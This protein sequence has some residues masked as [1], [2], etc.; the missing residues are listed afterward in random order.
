[1][2]WGTLSSKKWCLQNVR[3]VCGR[4]LKRKVLNQFSPN[5]EDTYQLSQ[6]WCTRW[7]FERFWKSIPIWAKKVLS[8]YKEW[9]YWF[10]QN[11]GQ[12]QP[13]GFHEV[14]FCC[15]HGLLWGP[16]LRE[17]CNVISKEQWHFSSPQVID[18][19]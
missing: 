19:Y 17:Q 5:L 10:W 6:Y 14:I 2:F 11:L 16:P 9:L 18:K 15:L 7:I 13:L 1:M 3:L 4:A 8:F 12:E